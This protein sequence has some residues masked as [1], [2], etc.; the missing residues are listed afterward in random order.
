M[1]PEI[2]TLFGFP[3]VEEAIGKDVLGLYMSRIRK[4]VAR[5]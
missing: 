1:Q 4:E 3:S 5:F 2:L